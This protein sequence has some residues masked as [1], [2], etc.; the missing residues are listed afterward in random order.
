MIDVTNG[1]GFGLDVTSLILDILTLDSTTP[2]CTYFTSSM[3][4]SVWILTTSA[5]RYDKDPHN[6][7]SIGTTSPNKII[8]MI[9]IIISIILSYLL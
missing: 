9:L 1:N 7:Y 3:S 5:D 6:S 2:S 8:V 4:F